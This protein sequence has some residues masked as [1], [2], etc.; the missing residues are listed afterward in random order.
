M[1]P[2]CS[3]PPP[4]WA[5][6]LRPAQ[7]I[8]AALVLLGALAAPAHAERVV[9]PR[10]RWDVG[11]DLI[12]LWGADLRLGWERDRGALDMLGLRA[13]WVAGPSPIF[14]SER[15]H[16]AAFVA[17]VVDLFAEQEWQL[18]L[19]AGPAALDRDSRGDAR[20]AF[21]DTRGWVTGFAARYKT[22]GW[23]QIN[24]GLMMIADARFR[25]RV[26]VVD[27]GPAWVW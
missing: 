16:A 21:D 18:E 15:T 17:P 22:P 24:L 7:R 6:R 1:H 20:I 4:R 3:S 2:S 19:T 25:E 14:G 5:S 10:H 26:V 9:R 23:F 27:I 11:V 8:L 12:G 13:G